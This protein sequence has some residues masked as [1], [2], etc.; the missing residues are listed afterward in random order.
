MRSG[1]DLSPA[2][3]EEPV[4]RSWLLEHLPWPEVGRALARDPRLLLPVG[5]LVQHGPH[6]PLGTNTLISEAVART[7]SHELEILRAPA[8][9]YGVR[10]S[11]RESFAGAAGIQR[12][13]LHRALN[14]LLAE[15]EDH[16]VQEFV[17]ITAHRLEAHIEALLM[18]MPTSATT[19]VVN[20]FSIEVDPVVEGSPLAEHGGELETSLMLHLAPELVRLDQARDVILEPRAFRKYARGRVPTPP[21]GSRGILGAPSRATAEKGAAVFSRYIQALKEILKRRPTDG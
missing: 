10:G 2:E 17:L 15:W 21:P 9:H 14:E 18:T 13:T 3:E 19:T 8:F 20:L 7:L 5:A 1:K 6:L 4:S 11:E 12:K 16:G